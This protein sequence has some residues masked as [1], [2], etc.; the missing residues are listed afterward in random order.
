MGASP[1][2]R[3]TRTCVHACF[4]HYAAN[5]ARTQIKESGKVRHIGITGLPF[6]ALRYVIDRVQPG[7]LESVL[8]YCHYCLNDDSLVAEMPYFSKAGL[9]IINASPLSMGLLTHQGPPDWHPAPPALLEAAREAA[10]LCQRRG[11]DLPKVAVSWALQNEGIATTLVGM[12]QPEQV[13]ANV[14]TALQA[15]GL[16]ENADKEKENEALAAVIK[17]LEP[18]RNVS[19]PSGRTENNG[20]TVLTSPKK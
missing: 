19:W 3:M 14:R 10:A 16:E 2:S 5:L 9:G 6:F 1:W 7:V 8:S 11:V 17:I 13:R 18:V 15:L 12:C 4:A 20:A